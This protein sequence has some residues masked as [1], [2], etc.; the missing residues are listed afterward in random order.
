MVSS[1]K[2]FLLGKQIYWTAKNLPIMLS[3]GMAAV[4]VGDIPIL[5]GL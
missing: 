3:K 5:C 1:V 4:V 2:R